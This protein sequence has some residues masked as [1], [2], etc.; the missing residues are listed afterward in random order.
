MPKQLDPREQRFVDEYLLDLDP[1]R[2]ALAAGYA[3]T[4]AS[5]KSFGWVSNSQ[6][7]KPHV[8]AAVAKAKAERS[9]RTKIDADWALERL[10]R[11]ADASV[12]DFLVIPDD[13]N[14]SPHFDL[15]DATPEQLATIEG[16]QL[17]RSWV[18]GEDGGTVDK[19]KI[20]LPSKLRALELIGKHVDV[21]AFV[22]RKEITGKDRG[23]IQ[24]EDVTPMERARRIGN[25]LRKVVEENPDYRHG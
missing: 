3:E 4:T 24:V 14:L 2:A 7:T 5:T 19:I 1:K 25:A 12:G 23:P 20:T 21:Q 18:G 6:S 13:S 15:R 22:E 17:D 9:E 11:L 8:F 16:L 10:A